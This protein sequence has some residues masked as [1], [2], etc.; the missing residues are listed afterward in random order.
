MSQQFWPLYSTLPGY[1]ASV[2]AVGG[3]QYQQQ[4]PECSQN[5][6]KVAVENGSHL[7]RMT[8]DAAPSLA[9]KHSGREGQCSPCE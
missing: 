4:L 9:L 7:L 6:M 5:V 8:E 3:L 2:T 1:L